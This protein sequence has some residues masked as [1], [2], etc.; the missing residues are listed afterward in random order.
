MNIQA[1]NR[2]AHSYVQQLVAEPARVFP[3]L[4]PVREADWIEGWNP[5]L[6]V[7]ASGV[8]EPDCVFTTAAEPG[9][10]IWYVT[11]HEADAGFVEMLKITPGVTACRLRIQLQA[12]AAGCDAIVTYMHTSL[13]VEGDAFV[14]GFTAA[15]YEQFMRDWEAR[16][17][18]YLEHGT[19]LAGARE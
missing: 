3:L 12:S 16:L 19:A 8:A 13:G 15:Y 10:A 11:R 2:V 18:H 1:P 7:S 14:A 5:L 9:D 4:C 6:V 17:N